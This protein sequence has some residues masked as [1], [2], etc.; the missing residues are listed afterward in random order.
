MTALLWARFEL[1]AALAGLAALAAR[2]AKEVALRGASELGRRWWEQ[3]Q[4]VPVSEV[5]TSYHRG[6]EPF[7]EH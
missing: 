3:R 2:V 7:L 1:L 4:R 5:R 6:V